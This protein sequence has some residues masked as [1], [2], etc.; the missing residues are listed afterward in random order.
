M[1]PSPTIH[2]TLLPESQKP[3]SDQKHHPE[4][5]HD[6]CNQSKVQRHVRHLHLVPPLRPRNEIAVVVDVWEFPSVWYSIAQELAKRLPA[7]LDLKFQKILRWH[8]SP[9]FVIMSEVDFL[10]L[11]NET[12]LE[13]AVEEFLQHG[14][15]DSRASTDMLQPLYIV[16]SDS[17]PH[18]FQRARV[19]AV[20]VPVREDHFGF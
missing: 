5:D 3:L 20:D 18:S 16:I 12:A 7:M 15:V 11:A 10:A 19:P 4:E 8:H 1:E 17:P 13:E 2:I 6:Q 9:D 14:V